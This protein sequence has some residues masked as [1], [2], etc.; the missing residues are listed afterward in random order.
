ML[1]SS[2]PLPPLPGLAS[3]RNFSLAPHDQTPASPL[4]L[5]G[6]GEVLNELERPEAEEGALVR[7]DSALLLVRALIIRPRACHKHI[8]INPLSKDFSLAMQRRSRVQDNA[9][10]VS[11][12]RGS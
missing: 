8:L 4:D 10:N 9:R 5:A 6:L 7:S 3:L 12:P 11:S 1:V 2:T